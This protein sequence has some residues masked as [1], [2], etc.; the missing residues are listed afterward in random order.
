MSPSDNSS[1][2]SAALGTVVVTAR[3]IEFSNY[4]SGTSKWGGAVMTMMILDSVTEGLE[5]YNERVYAVFR[6]HDDPTDLI[7]FSSEVDGLDTRVTTTDP[8]VPSAKYEL[9]K[10]YGATSGGEYATTSQFYFQVPGKAW[11]FTNDTVGT[12]DITLVSDWNNYGEI[13]T[14][15]K[16]YKI[17]DAADLPAMNGKSNSSQNY[18]WDFTVNGETVNSADVTGI[19]LTSLVDEAVFPNN[20]RGY[21]T[22]RMDSLEDVDIVSSRITTLSGPYVQNPVHRFAIPETV[23]R[24]NAFLRGGNIV[25]AGNTD[26]RTFPMYIPDSVTWLSTFMYGVWEP[27]KLHMSPNVTRIS[28]SYYR[29]VTLAKTHYVLPDNTTWTSGMYI[30][31]SVSQA[32]GAEVSFD[33]DKNV[34]SSG[35]NSYYILSQCYSLK[36]AGDIVLPGDFVKLNSTISSTNTAT[37]LNKI[38]FKEG[39]TEIGNNTCFMVGYYGSG[40]GTAQNHAVIKLP[41]SLTKIGDSCFYYLNRTSYV[42]F[43]F[44]TGLTT[45]GTDCLSYCRLYGNQIKIPG[46]VTSIG[47]FFHHTYSPNGLDLSELSSPNV[48]S[49]QYSFA[50]SSTRTINGEGW[51]EVT[52][53]PGTIDAWAARFP[54]YYNNSSDWRRVIWKERPTQYGYVFYV[55]GYETSNPTKHYVELQSMT[56]FNKFVGTGSSDRVISVDDGEGGTVDLHTYSV[57]NPDHNS[58]TGFHVGTDITTLQDNFLNY[59]RTLS[60]FKFGGNETTIGGYVLYH[61]GDSL[62]NVVQN[63][64]LV[65]IP[66]T[67]T[68]IG[69]QSFSYMRY[70]NEPISVPSSLTSLY[71]IF[72]H[73]ESFNQTFTIADGVTNLTSFL[74]GCKAFNQPLS[75]PASVTNVSAMLDYCDNF[76]STITFAQGISI[77][78]ATAFL[79][80]CKS[81]NQP[82]DVFWLSGITGSSLSNFMYECKAFNQPLTIPAFTNANNNFTIEYFLHNCTAFNSTITFTDLSKVKYLRYFMSNCTSFNKPID[83]STCQSNCGF[84][85]LNGCTSFNS[86]IIFPPSLSATNG[87]SW[88][89]NC[90]SFN[91]PITMPVYESGAFYGQPPAGWKSFNQPLT[92]P[93]SWSKSSWYNGGSLLCN[94]NSMTSTVTVEASVPSGQQAVFDNS[95]TV[96]DPTAPAY[97][98]GITLT[99]TYAQVWK[100]ACPDL[101]GTQTTPAGKYRKIIVV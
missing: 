11:D 77:T 41:N 58:I 24:L 78:S 29:E 61:A 81:F 6:N 51:L 75:I 98:N 90:T 20:S 89:E 38:E 65:N 17:A 12:D 25:N 92:I 21:L 13:V 8:M 43:E 31:A 99:G 67:V 63:F 45:I 79:R 4:N 68:S 91:Q 19:R 83:F 22:R 5:E 69:G 44:G 52:V 18:N 95:F 34:T 100:D 86:T 48:V 37:S 23:T 3:D 28:D 49:Q 40:L 57:R 94:F 55:T 76:N 30:F 59:F 2:S 7:E 10:I 33:L 46:T 84:M 62:Y 27:N 14:T 82:L 64:D 39:I 50:N 42:D 101:D 73:N 72:H 88:M 47:S 60:D 80:G 16:T 15:T 70:M 71:N 26:L 1:S 54:N 97:V 96:T 93:S 56:D 74:S 53:E 9:Y 35:N 32:N 87:G 85:V 66:S 36:L